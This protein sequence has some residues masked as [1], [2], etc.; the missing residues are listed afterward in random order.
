[1][2]ERKLSEADIKEE[3]AQRRLFEKICFECGQAYYS[4]D[5]DSL[6]CKTCWQKE[7]DKFFKENNI[8]NI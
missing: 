3:L 7:L 6:Y 2:K 1:M 8:T 5:E 4:N